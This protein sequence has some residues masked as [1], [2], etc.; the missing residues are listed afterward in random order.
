M[1]GKV[2]LRGHEDIPI[3]KPV[4]QYLGHVI[5]HKAYIDETKN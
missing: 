4:F 1:G 5:A 2:G 3:R